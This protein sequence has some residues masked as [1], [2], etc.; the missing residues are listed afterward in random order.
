M[1]LSLENS[2]AR[3]VEEVVSKVGFVVAVGGSLQ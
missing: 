2:F 3:R 1:D